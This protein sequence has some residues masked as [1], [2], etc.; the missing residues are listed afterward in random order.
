VGDEVVVGG[1]GV[2]EG[3]EE[4]GVA[5]AAGADRLDDNVELFREAA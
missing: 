1:E 5:E 2:E 3:A 4:G